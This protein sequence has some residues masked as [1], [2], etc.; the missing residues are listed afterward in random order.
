MH[1]RPVVAAGKGIV[2]PLVNWSGKESIA[3][4]NIT[5]RHAAIA[6]GMKATMAS[7]AAVATRPS[8]VAGVGVYVLSDFNVADALIIRA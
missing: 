8:T 3:S 4:L 2:V 7:G 5:V 6:I 1:G